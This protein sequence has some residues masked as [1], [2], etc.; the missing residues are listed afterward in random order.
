MQVKPA[1]RFALITS[2]VLIGCSKPSNRASTNAPASSASVALEADAGARPSLPLDRPAVPRESLQTPPLVAPPEAQQGPGGVRFLV[3]HQGTGEAPGPVDTI[4]LDFSMWTGDGQLA[5]SSFPD[6]TPAG[7]SVS[8][9]APNLRVLLTQ[10]K[11]GSEARLWVPRAALAGWKPP[12]WPDT[13][14]IFDLKLISVSHVTVKDPEGN[15]VQP[16]PV[17]LPDAAGPPPSAERTKSGLRFVYLAHS[18]N[19]ELPTDDKRLELRVV[20]YAIDGIEVKAVR[21]GMKTA[22]TLQRAPGRLREVLSQLKSGDRVRIWL[23]KGEGRAIIPEVGARESI[24]DLAVS[25]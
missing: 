20:A 14:L 11:V 24:L 8:T 3:S 7:F 13:D 5:V 25:F 9:L 4:I 1:L 18:E 21:D 6:A 17:S 19:K 2:F 16:V 23:P 12:D 10:L 22:T 15:V